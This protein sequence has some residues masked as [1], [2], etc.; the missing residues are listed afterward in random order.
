M[1]VYL[2]QDALAAH[3]SYEVYIRKNG[4]FIDR[5]LVDKFH[6][7]EK[8]MREVLD[9]QSVKVSRLPFDRTKFAAATK[10]GNSL[11]KALELEVQ[12]RLWSADSVP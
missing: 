12:R 8:L 5:H 1:D 2:L 4:I 7:I 6:E 11:I 10:K 9:E 3:N